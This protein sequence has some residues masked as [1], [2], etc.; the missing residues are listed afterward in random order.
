V[1]WAGWAVHWKREHDELDA[2]ARQHGATILG[3]HGHHQLMRMQHFYT[4]VADILG[5][6]ADIVQPRTFEELER[7]GFEDPPTRP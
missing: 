5:T 6:L 2:L 4:Q 1:D 7:Y 3:E